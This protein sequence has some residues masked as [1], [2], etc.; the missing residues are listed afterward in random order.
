MVPSGMIHILATS[1]LHWYVIPLSLEYV[2][3]NKGDTGYHVSFSLF[4]YLSQQGLKLFFETG[5]LFRY[6]QFKKEDSFFFG[7]LF[8][9]HTHSIF[10]FQ[11]LF[12]CCHPL[13]QRFY[14]ISQS[15]LRLCRNIHR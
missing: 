3:S 1:L 15:F 2:L 14:H 5:V 6:I 11:P 12:R 7:E 4:A 10:I 8:Y 9:S 13:G